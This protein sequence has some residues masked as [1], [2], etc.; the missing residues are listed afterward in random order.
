MNLITEPEF[1]KQIIKRLDEYWSSHQFNIHTLF[2]W[3]VV[4]GPGRSGAILAVYLSH[5]LGIPF[6]PFVS[7]QVPDTINGVLLVDTCEKSGRTLKKAK[8]KLGKNKFVTTFILY[9]EPPRV[10]FWYEV[11]GV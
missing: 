10:R 6:M 5:L 8:S 11:L 3:D 7:K 4:M 1:A 2:K 9:K